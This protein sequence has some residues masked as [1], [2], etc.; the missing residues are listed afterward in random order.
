MPTEPR[1]YI[2]IATHNETQGTGE[3]SSG[4]FR[5]LRCRRAADLARLVA[6]IPLPD[7]SA[8]ASIQPSVGSANALIR[9]QQSAVS[10]L[11][12][13]RLHGSPPLDRVRWSQLIAFLCASLESTRRRRETTASDDLCATHAV[14]GTPQN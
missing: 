1:S 11:P 3:R 9:C 10:A 8:F 14:S 12:G 6:A 7:E 4:P 13:R 2:G 5:L